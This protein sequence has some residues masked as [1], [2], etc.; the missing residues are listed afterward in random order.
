MHSNL[1]F[2]VSA[3][4]ISAIFYVSGLGYHDQ[5]ILASHL[6]PRFCDLYS[7]LS[8]GVVS[9]CISGV[10]FKIAL[11]KEMKWKMLCRYWMLFH[12]EISP[13]KLVLFVLGTLS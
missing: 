4:L 7:F 12:P 3:G 2:K 1:S 6:V 8:P 10:R 5:I 9:P 11:N 13:L